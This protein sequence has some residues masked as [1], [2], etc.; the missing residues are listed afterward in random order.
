M[1][2]GD[3]QSVKI[4]RSRRIPAAALEEYVEKLTQARPVAS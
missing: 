3:L 4:G 1:A 2:S